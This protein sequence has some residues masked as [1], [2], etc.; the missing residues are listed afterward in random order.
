MANYLLLAIIGVMILGAFAQA[1]VQSTF[2]KYSDL[3]T[4]SGRTASEV[5]RSLLSTHGSNVKVGAVQGTLTDNYNPKTG[6]VSLSQS[7]YSSTSVSAV[8]VAAHECGHVMQYESG[9]G[10]IKFRNMLLP[11]ANFGAR[12]SYILVLVGVIMGSMGYYVSLAGVALFAVVF[13]FQ[14]LTLP[15]ELNASDRAIAMLSE[16]GYIRGAEQEEGARQVLKAAAF[17][18]FVSV[19]SSALMLMRLFAIASS[20]RRR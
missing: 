16:G 9:Y 18:Y 7:V 12:F 3:P 11:A 4:G 20:G 13:L 19:L 8:A 1:K 6:Q 14:L 17:T 5:A 10:P 15:I 2:K